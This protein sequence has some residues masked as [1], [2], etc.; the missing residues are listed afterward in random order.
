MKTGIVP[1]FDIS[2]LVRIVRVGDII[3][4]AKFDYSVLVER[5]IRDGFKVFEITGD[6]LFFIPNSFREEVMERMVS[7]SKKYDIDYTVHLPIW[8]VELSSP[9]KF[10]RDAS[11]EA[12]VKTINFFEDL[13]PINY[14]IHAFGALASE[15]SRLK[16]QGFRRIVLSY[17]QHFA[18]ESIERILDET[19]I[20]P[21]RLAIENVEFPWDLTREVV[22]NVGT[23]ICYDTGHLHSGQAGK[24]DPINFLLDNFDKIIELHFHDAVPKT[25]PDDYI[26][27]DHLPL[28]A[29]TL[30]FCKIIEILLDKRFKGPLIFELKYDEIWESLKSI[31]DVCGISLDEMGFGGVV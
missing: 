10:I 2:E 27:K 28:G 15:F 1:L 4:F 30:P 20:K 12:C 16:L 29:G 19:G 8:S 13:K 25:N 11:V 26:Y 24:L 22:D 18:I 23:S 9:N 6:I 17:F 5:G 14:V 7:L 21:S 31:R 3:D